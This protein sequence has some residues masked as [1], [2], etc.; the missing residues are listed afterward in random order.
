MKRFLLFFCLFLTVT[1]LQPRAVKAFDLVELDLDVTIVDQSFTFDYSQLNSP[2]TGFT[3]LNP[4]LFSLDVKSAF[5][6]ELGLL[7][8]ENLQQG[9]SLYDGTLFLEVAKTDPQ[10][11]RAQLRTTYRM[12]LDPRKLDRTYLRNLF[13][14]Q[15]RYDEVQARAMARAARLADARLMRFDESSERWVRAASRVRARADV[16][17]RGRRAE[18]GVLGHYGYNVDSEGNSYVWAV[19]DRNSKYA[20]GINVDDDDDGVFNVDD[21]CRSISNPDQMDTDLDSVGNACDPDDDNDGIEDEL[22]NCPLDLNPD[23]EDLD[24]DGAGD[25]CDT[26][27]DN[28]GVNDSIDQCQ[29]TA[30]SALIDGEGCSIEDRCP[31]VNE[32]GWKNHGSYVRCVAK[33]SEVFV[34]SGLLSEA[35]KDEIVSASASSACGKR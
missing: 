30:P 17:Y 22:D 26:D 6:P 8:G 15:G 5:I 19:L 25:I 1:T 12:N 10:S 29:T 32:S 9:F 34:D 33:A 3:L 7:P 4:D 31:C 28:D 23:Q 14:R 13:V 11:G 20:V 35:E 16:R 2:R 24:Q 27:D 18:D 21:N